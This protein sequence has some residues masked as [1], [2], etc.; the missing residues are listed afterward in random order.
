MEEVGNVT[1][2]RE[3]ERIVRRGWLRLRLRFK[4]LCLGV[5]GRCRAEIGGYVNPY[6]RG[7]NAEDAR[8]HEFQPLTLNRL[9]PSLLLH[10]P[11]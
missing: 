2:K 9:S 1:G 11:L 10:P 4:V 7:G 3:R 5:N 6:K 8:K